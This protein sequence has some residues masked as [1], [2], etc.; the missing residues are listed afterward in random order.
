MQGR[1]VYRWIVIVALL[2]L[3]SVVARSQ[4]FRKINSIECVPDSTVWSVDGTYA[5]RRIDAMRIER[6]DLVRSIVI[7]TIPNVAKREFGS[8]LGFI[9]SRLYCCSF[10]NNPMRFEL[11]Y[12]DRD[13]K[14]WTTL[15]AYNVYN[16]DANRYFKYATIRVFQVPGHPQA[17]VTSTFG[18]DSE[19][20]PPSLSSGAKTYV[21]DTASHDTLTTNF[22]EYINAS[23]SPSGSDI[24]SG[25]NLYIAF[26]RGHS[27]EQPIGW[28]FSVDSL[29]L[30]HKSEGKEYLPAN[31]KYVLDTSRLQYGRSIGSQSVVATFR[32]GEVGLVDLETLE[33]MDLRMNGY[34]YLGAVASPS[35]ILAATWQA[36]GRRLVVKDLA[37][38]IEE[39]VDTISSRVT[40]EN[41]T[42]NMVDSIVV[43]CDPADS[44]ITRYKVYG[45]SGTQGLVVRNSVDTAMQ[46]DT[47]YVNAFYLGTWRPSAYRWIVGGIR[48]TTATGVLRFPCPRTGTVNVHVAAVDTAGD[49]ISVDTGKSFY[50]TLPKRAASRVRVTQSPFV[51]SYA[52]EPLYVHHVSVDR[53]ERRLGVSQQG[54]VAELRMKEDATDP[55]DTTVV[56]VEQHLIGG[57]INYADSAGTGLVLLGK[58]WMETDPSLTTFL[59]VGTSLTNCVQLDRM[60][61]GGPYTESDADGYYPRDFFYYEQFASFNDQSDSYFHWGRYKGGNERYY[62]LKKGTS[63]LIRR[64]DT[65]VVIRDIFNG[66]REISPISFDFDYGGNLVTTTDSS[67]NVFDGVSGTL[68]TSISGGWLDAIQVDPTTIVTTGAVISLA[69]STP[70][71][72]ETPVRLGIDV[73]RISSEYSAIICDEGTSVAYVIRNTTGEIIDSIEAMP[74]HARCGVYVRR[75]NAL[76]IGDDAGFVTTYPLSTLVTVDEPPSKPL[77]DVRSVAVSASSPIVH[78][79]TLITSVDLY[80]G[81]GAHIG[82]IQHAVGSSFTGSTWDLSPYQLTPGVYLLVAHGTSNTVVQTL[83]LW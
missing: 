42:V 58:G 73:V 27:G 30:I 17:V 38:G 33:W 81:V 55:Y 4:V 62:L 68:L 69:G 75:W 16:F 26:S 36:G 77:H 57:C 2:P 25:W 28:L 37:S 52:N 79:P 9:G 31:R 63:L 47:V 48:Y 39:V 72:Q 43:V 50:V 56:M 8:T 18:S 53:D 14:V 23:W 6:I 7:D 71:I 46:H 66:R 82:E 29:A 59:A 12:I 44:T 41:V 11:K 20:G 76:L 34:A 32:G 49:T 83:M 51:H 70:R 67:V 35:K 80:T 24:Y 64:V 54:Q 78:L 40:T 5:A 3:L 74:N 22:D 1:W 21:I 19:N 13:Q 45:Y 65:G 15:P 61:C 10:R 60:N